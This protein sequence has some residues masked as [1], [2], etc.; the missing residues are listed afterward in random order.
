MERDSFEDAAVGALHPNNHALGRFAERGMEAAAYVSA[1]P[2][3]LRG[4]YTLEKELSQYL[5]DCGWLETVA[6]VSGIA[7]IETR[8][9]DTELPERVADMMRRSETDQSGV[10]RLAGERLVLEGVFISDPEEDEPSVQLVWRD[11]RDHEDCDYAIITRLNDLTGA[12]FTHQP[13]INIE[14]R[15]RTHYPE[16]YELLETQVPPGL[17]LHYDYSALC[18]VTWEIA[19]ELYV[20]YTEALLTERLRCEDD[21]RWCVVIDGVVRSLSDKKEIIEVETQEPLENALFVGL[22]MHEIQKDTYAPWL[23]FAVAEEGDPSLKTLRMVSPEDIVSIDDM[24]YDVNRH[25]GEQALFGTYDLDPAYVNRAIEGAARKGVDSKEP[26]T[27]G[28]YQEVYDE[29]LGAWRF[30]VPFLK[31]VRRD[32]EQG[33]EAERV[34]E[35]A[36]ELQKELG[37]N[38]LLHVAEGS[39]VV[40][41]TVWG[42]VEQGRFLHGRFAG[43]AAV[44]I[45]DSAGQRSAAAVMLVDARYFDEDGGVLRSFG[46]EAVFA[47]VDDEA[48]ISELRYGAGDATSPF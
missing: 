9:E 46:N 25:F 19:E 10:Y 22:K 44:S 47:V 4:K 41:E 48:D 34:E 2:E 17:D 38:S 32:V 3:D 27:E 11:P 21:A 33:A 30:P 5:Q 43:V 37:G 16:L 31:I 36:L 28:I 18:G 13:I 7:Y 8:D 20:R 14:H 24:S 26:A 23:V 40:S 15:L 1:R 12:E 39:M 45:A 6:K 29:Q 42:H 35:M